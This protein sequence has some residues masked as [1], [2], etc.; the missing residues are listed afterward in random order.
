MKN[1][2]LLIILL[3]AL[4]D[5][6][7]R[8]QAG[9]TGLAF[10][11]LGAGARALGM[12]EAFTAVASDPSATYYNPS[13]LSYSGEPQ[14][15]LMHK[16]W[17]QDTRTEFLAATT[18]L[19]RLALG[20]SVNGTTISDI[21]L[22]TVPGPASE[23]FTARN[24]AIG[25]SAAYAIDTDMSL[26]VTGKYLFEKIL[27]DE[28]SG[29]AL[30]FGATYIT[31]WNIR[32]GLA[33]TNIGSMNELRYDAT[34]LPEASRCGGSYQVRFEQLDAVLTCAADIVSYSG[35]D[36]THGLFGAEFDYPH[37]FAVRLG[38]QTS[39]E[40]KD[41]SAGIGIH[42]NIVRLDYAYVPFKYDLGT[43]HTF[44]LSIEFL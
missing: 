40:S 43:T 24:S 36:I 29:Y 28:A 13:G 19:D 5:G 17:I 34:K 4:G 31:P 42:C 8:A 30:D 10:L 3:L 16:S 39:Y 18:R 6:I 37:T 21:E 23:T 26:G 25:I 20:L 15:L 9:N 22:R 32:L 14:L 12:G 1:K 11:K 7:A 2:L 38:Y 27:A 41:F 35:E 33:L 44:S